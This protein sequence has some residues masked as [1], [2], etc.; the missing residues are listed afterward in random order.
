MILL[1]YLNKCKDL[2]NIILRINKKGAVILQQPLFINR[3]VQTTFLI[4]LHWCFHHFSEFPKYTFP[5][6]GLSRN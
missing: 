1:H 4:F 6:L 2:K 3:N 5:N